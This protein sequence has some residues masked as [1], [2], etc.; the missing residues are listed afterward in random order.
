[1]RINVEKIVR[2]WQLQGQNRPKVARARLELFFAID[3]AALGKVVGGHF[4]LDPVAGYNLD[5]V[6]SHSA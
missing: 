2:N 3:Y 5:V 4:N 6:L 1:M